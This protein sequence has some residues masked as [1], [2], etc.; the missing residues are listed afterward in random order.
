MGWVDN[1]YPITALQYTFVD[2][3]SN[4][5]SLPIYGDGDNWNNYRYIKFSSEEYVVNLIST[6]PYVQA[7]INVRYF[8]VG[9]ESNYVMSSINTNARNAYGVY[10]NCWQLVD[11]RVNAGAQDATQ[12]ITGNKW[13]TRDAFTMGDQT[14]PTRYITSLDVVLC[15]KE[16]SSRAVGWLNWYSINFLK[17]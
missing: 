5:T 11:F 17:S 6:F 15:I 16:A 7:T 2:Y 4:P 10:K 9:N 12:T 1:S 14:N 13:S 3:G 8:T